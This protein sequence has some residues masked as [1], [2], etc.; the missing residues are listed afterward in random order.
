MISPFALFFYAV[1]NPVLL[2][3][4]R[5]PATRW[6]TAFFLPHMVI[7]PD[8][9]V[10]AIRMLGSVAFIARCGR[11]KR[12][13]RR[14]RLLATELNGTTPHREECVERTRDLVSPRPRARMPR[15]ICL[16]LGVAVLVVGVVTAAIDVRAGSAQHGMPSP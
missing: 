10:S 1:F 7:S 9:A 15:L 8:P 12:S 3:L 4:D 6:L 5:V 16:K 14:R 13:A 11:R 2:A